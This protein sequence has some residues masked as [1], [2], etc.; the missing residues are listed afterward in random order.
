MIQYC[1]QRKLYFERCSNIVRKE[2]SKFEDIKKVESNFKS[3][4]Q[5]N[6][7]DD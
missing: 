6:V 3:F 2:A 5:P 7:F 1:A 4:A